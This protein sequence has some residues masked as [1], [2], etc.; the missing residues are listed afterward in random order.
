MRGR[1]AGPTALVDSPGPSGQIRPEGCFLFVA[2]TMTFVAGA[3]T[4]P[5]R[6]GGTRGEND[7]AKGVQASPSSSSC[8]RRCAG[9]A[10]DGAAA[11]RSGVAGSAASCRAS[12][13]VNQRRQS[14]QRSQRVSRLRP[15]AVA[16]LVVRF[17][18]AAGRSPA[19]P[20]L[21][22]GRSGFRSRRDANGRS[23]D[24]TTTGAGDNNRPDR[25]RR[26]RRTGH[27]SDLPRG[28]T[29]WERPESGAVGM[30]MV[31]GVV[32]REG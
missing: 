25:D 13:N 18:C 14:P 17:E 31:F 10:R 22:R 5:S 2:C 7:V 21:G 11:C 8:D 4:A 9:G 3:A 23:T 15:W 16:V 20:D 26:A 30:P 27:R 32:V 6:R 29:R 24:A 28:S 1:A 12:T 19:T